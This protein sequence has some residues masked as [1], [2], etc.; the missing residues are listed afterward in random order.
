MVGRILELQGVVTVGSLVTQRKS[1]LL[2]RGIQGDRVRVVGEVFL[3]G[4]KGVVQYAAV[5]TIGRMNALTW[6]HSGTRSLLRRVLATL[7]EAATVED[8]V[9][10]LMV[11][12]EVGQQQEMLAV[13]HREQWNVQGVRHPQSYHSVLGVRHPPASPIVFYTVRVSWCC[14]SRIDQT[15]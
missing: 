3:L 2:S 1:T 8:R 15:L 5:R 12:E 10:G 4:G 14:L 7:L 11:V 9:V 13:T 6:E